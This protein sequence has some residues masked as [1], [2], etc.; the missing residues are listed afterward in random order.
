MGAGRG[1]GG[2][3]AG[4]DPDPALGRP[5]AAGVLVGRQPLARLRGRDRRRRAHPGV[6]GAARRQRGAADRGRPG[7]ARRARP[8]GAQRSSRGRHPPVT[9]R[10]ATDAV[11]PRGSAHGPARRDRGRRP[12]PCARPVA[13]GAV[14]RHLRRRARQAVLRRGRPARG[15][16]HA[17]AARGHRLDRDRA[18]PPGARGRHRSAVR[19]PR[20]RRGAAA[21]AADRAAVRAERPPRRAAHARAPRRRRAR[22]RRRR[23]RRAAAAA[24]L[25]RRRVERARALRHDHAGAH[26]GEWP[27]GTRRHDPG[28]VP[29]RAERGAR[30]RGTHP[31]QGA[32]AASTSAPPAGAG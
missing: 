32:V 26:G 28:A 13:R 11:V 6:G 2:R 27:A 9:R 23:R 19:V 4:R 25:E 22:G 1:A 21:E 30:R 8:L 15:P 7:R 3:C 29:R 16:A 10:G 31:A 17:P 24:R 12:H 18:H 20:L 5:G 14:H